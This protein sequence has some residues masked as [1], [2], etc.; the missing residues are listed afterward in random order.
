[1]ESKLGKGDVCELPATASVWLTDDPQ[2]G[3]VL[4]EFTDA[5]GRPHQLVDKSAIFGSDLHPTSAYPRPTAVRCTIEDINGEIATV[6]VHWVPSRVTDM[7]FTF[8]VRLDTLGPVA[9]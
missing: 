8:E 6:S 9:V 5:I 4:V 3:L 1:M 7:P 2:P